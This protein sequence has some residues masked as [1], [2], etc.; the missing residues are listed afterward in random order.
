MR[1]TAFLA[2]MLPAALFAQ[3]L[4][5]TLRS[6]IGDFQGTVTLYAKNLDTGA[7]VGIREADPVRTA[8]TIKLP[9]LCAVF[10]QVARGKARWDEKLTVTASA[11][12]SGSGVLGAE[13]SDGVQLPL[14]DV[15]HLMIVLS[16]NTATNMILERF[17]ADTVNEY[18]DKIGIPTTRSLRKILGAKGADGAS[19][20]GKLPENQKYGLGVSTPRDMVT[21]LE[22]LDRGE[23]V[24]PEAS[25]EILA[26]LKRC[27]D[28]TGV[29]R[30]LAGAQ[31][32]N[33][34]GAL[35]A[36]RS[37]TALVTV[38]GVRIALA[39][40]V[41]NMP[42]PDWT[43]ENPGSNMIADLGKLIVDNLTRP[44]PAATTSAAA[45]GAGRGGRGNAPPPLKF[46][47]VL[48][49]RRVTFR[50]RAPQAMQ[51]AVTGDFVQGPQ[52][53]QRGDDSV[54]SVTLGP[55]K[56]A[57]YNYGLRVDGVGVIDPANPMIKQGESGASSMLEV[58][59][60]GL[61]PYDWQPVPHG[62]VHVNWYQSKT[63]D[64]PRRI[65]VYTPA[66][67]ETS[68]ATYPVLY[69]LH[70]SGDTETGWTNVGRADM[71]LDN[72]IAAG[73]AK[74]M[75]VVMPYGRARRDVYL[76][77]ITTQPDA[78]QFENDLLKDV[79]PFAEKLYRISGKAEDRAIAG[80][81][82]GGGQA[83]NIGLH[84]LELF[85]WVG[86]FS[87]AARGPNLEEQFKDLLT[88]PAATNKKL[89]VLYIACGKT[90]SLFPAS[91]QFHEILDKHQVRNQFVASEEG[92]VWRNW[93][94]Y[95]A[96]FTPQLFR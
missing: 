37:E 10:D 45:P 41:D 56:P 64:V 72:L 12:V 22:K 95:L 82:M 63:L 65:D 25:K 93:R 79:I 19:A 13:F 59:A 62:T 1:V 78:A 52:L 7:S 9:I 89:K 96:E 23:I 88:D 47:E 58:P 36:L 44:A 27:Q 49:D 55:L 85:H 68:K 46:Y 31:I 74:P 26:I 81:S 90:D 87:A 6:R 94:D 73:K 66:G 83:M 34:T 15:A 17:T 3:P 70:G 53:M 29:R 14:S 80:L 39:L 38:N 71:I 75:I 61:A 50:L 57:V 21:I 91:Q 67:Y 86:M 28:N 20:A 69:L 5:D 54:W 92:H 32:A 77:P 24:S 76:G 35:D 48:P 11:K 42:K 51:V 40:T 60:D 2:V 4:Q 43:P 30:R 33:K 8:S 16:D 84:H 18:L